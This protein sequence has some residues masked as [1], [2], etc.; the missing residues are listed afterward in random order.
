MSVGP[1]ML[2]ICLLPVAWLVMHRCAPAD[3]AQLQRG[4]QVYAE[5]CADCHG[6]R[7]EGTEENYPQALFGDKA[8][9]I[10]SAS[11]TDALS[12]NNACG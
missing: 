2:R 12:P 5:K 7:G 9:G 6:V 1:F 8:S 10:N 3:D 4:Q 11:S